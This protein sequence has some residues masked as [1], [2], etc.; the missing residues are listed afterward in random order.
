MVE[1][2]CLFGFE[3]SGSE[4]ISW[5]RVLRFK[6]S[7]LGSDTGKQGSKLSSRV[8]LEGLEIIILF[9]N[10]TYFDTK[11]GNILCDISDH[12]PQILIVD[13]TCPDYKS[14]SFA[15]HDFSHFDENKFVNGYS[16]LDLRSLNDDNVSVDDRFTS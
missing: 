1:A 14:C 9:S 8:G 12:F 6:G 10:I 3:N 11:S 4:T 2:T 5:A 16:A 13:R 7:E 15:K